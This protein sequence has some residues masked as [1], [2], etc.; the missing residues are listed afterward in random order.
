VTSLVGQPATAQLATVQSVPAD[1][2]FWVGTSDTNR[3]WV[4]L[5]GAGE[6]PQTVKAGDH[7]TF[8]GTE[9]ANPAGFSAQV[10]VDAG[11]APTS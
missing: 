5:T 8:T 1:E 10:G 3:I 4:Q 2:G 6:S 9:V 11:E 7:I